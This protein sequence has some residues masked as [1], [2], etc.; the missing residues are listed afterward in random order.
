MTKG[1][2]PNPRKLLVLAALSFSACQPVG[3]CLFT[4]SDGYDYCEEFLGTEYNGSAAQN[5]CED[6]D[7]GYS[8]SPCS[9]VGALGTCGIGTGTADDIQYIY[10]AAS[11][12]SDAGPVTTLILESACGVAGGVFTP[13]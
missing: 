12:G 4:T 5:T 6:E 10:T 8:Q 7:G 11:G 1:M 3:S 2:R 13:G 9:T